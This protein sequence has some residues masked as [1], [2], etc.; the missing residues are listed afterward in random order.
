MSFGLTHNMKG[1]LL[2]MTLIMAFT[3]TFPPL[4][5]DMKMKYFEIIDAPLNLPFSKVKA[6]SKSLQNESNSQPS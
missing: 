3:T 4:K 2:E 6:L 1:E 5:R